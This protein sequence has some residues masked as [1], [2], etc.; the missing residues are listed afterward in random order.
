M[1]LGGQLYSPAALSPEKECL[2][3]SG[4]RLGGPQSR[5]GMEA[6]AKKKNPCP[7]RESKPGPPARSLVT[8]LTEI[9]RLLHIICKTQKLEIKLLYFIYEFSV[10]PDTTGSRGFTSTPPCLRDLVHT[11]RTN[12]TL[13]QRMQGN[14]RMGF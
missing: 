8:I 1:E 3:P 14:K 13:G 2:V 4:W 9:F 11:H 5:S 7:Y 12:F 6:V 10:D